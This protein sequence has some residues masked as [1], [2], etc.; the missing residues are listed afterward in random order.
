M[1]GKHT[2]KPGEKTDLKVSFATINAPG[3]FEKIVTI[4]INAPETKQYEV[5][6]IGTVKEAPGAKINMTSRK[7]DAGVIRQ[8]ETRKT[9]IAI[10]NTGE[11]PLIIKAVSAKGGTGISV[12]GNSLPVAIPGG[13]TSEI[14]LA[15]SVSK[16]GVFTERV[17]IESNA[18]NVPK[19][20]YVIQV[21]GKAE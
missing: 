4:D 3:P 12:A 11:L 5:I 21:T 2:L 20:G 10:K 19:T 18:K 8:G 13:Q 9:K 16:P 15:V 7:V 1:L 14:E 17:F 6:M